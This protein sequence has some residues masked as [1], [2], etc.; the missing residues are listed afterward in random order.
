MDSLKTDFYQLI[1]TNEHLFDFILEAS[2]KGLCYCH[3][4]NNK[5]WISP[6][7]RQA[8]GYYSKQ[9]VLTAED[10]VFKD[11]L[12]FMINNL[13]GKDFDPSAQYL[14][15]YKHQNGSILQAH[16]TGI[17]HKDDK[18]TPFALFIAVKQFNHT[19]DHLEKL[20]GHNNELTKDHLNEKLKLSEERFRLAFQNAA[21]GMA[22]VSLEGKWL[23][24]NR[25]LFKILGYRPS[26]LL[27]L[28]FQ[29]IT[30]PEDL[31]KDIHLFNEI[32]EGIRDSYQMEKR[33]FHKNGHIVWVILTVSI[34]KDSNSKPLHFISQLTDITKLKA[35]EEEIKSV[36]DVT[37]DQ[38][39]R[40]LNFA[41]IVSHN[42]R[43]HSGNLSMLLN[44]IETDTDEQSRQELS[45]MFRHATT[46][47]QETVGHLNEVV[48]VNTTIENL[49]RVNLN[50]AIN[51]AIGNIEA[52]LRAANAICRNEVREDVMIDV[53]PAYLDSIL[54]NFL[55][56]AIK[57][58]SPDRFPIIIL[59]AET[60][61][62]KVTLSIRDNGM[63]ID[64]QTNREQ[65]F[66]MYKTFHKNKD[67]RGIGLFITKNQIEAM[68]GQVSIESEVGKGTTFT[69]LFKLRE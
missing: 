65:V 59:Q 39:R 33:Y 16:C 52:L 31:D 37:N 49:T 64:L 21:I 12:H 27:S 17:L 25:S 5:I 7:W 9:E 6:E 3:L 15:D 44:F 55:T 56:N 32:L 19:T 61:G 28:T 4:E 35:A 14:I 30:H 42:L 10:F 43:S 26:E 29:D 53:V 8:L 69:I 36:M 23:R 38:N 34:V 62:N 41:H 11:Q 57:Y 66:G 67:A 47:L 18:G 1:K 2:P 20:N 51:C 68:G 58:H 40:L 54:L 22:I 48:A 60:A 63:G 50:G 45:K 13:E 46:N 24:I